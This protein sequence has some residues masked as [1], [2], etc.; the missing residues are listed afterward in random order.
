V[1]N[2]ELKPTSTDNK[3]WQPKTPK[4][5]KTVTTVKTTEVFLALRMLHKLSKER[6]ASKI[7]E[8]LI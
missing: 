2:L 1:E 5:N 3:L 4:N 6:I 7:K 8:L